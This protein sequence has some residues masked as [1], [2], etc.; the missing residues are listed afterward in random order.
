MGIYS[1]LGGKLERIAKLIS[2]KSPR[3]RYSGE[4]GDVVL[5]R[6]LEVGSKRWRV[7]CNAK[8]D[9]V[10]LLA[11]INLPGA[12]QRRKSH[13]DE[14]QMRSFYSEGE[15]LVAEVQTLYQDGAL[16]L[17]TRNNRYGK[18]GYGELIRVQAGLM[19]RSRSHFAKLNSNVEVILGM[20]GLV[21]VGPVRPEIPE[22]AITQPV[23]TEV[24]LEIR[25]EISTVRNTILE[26]DRKFMSIDEASL[27]EVLNRK[28]TV[29]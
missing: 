15:V 8:Q 25:K 27:M 20:N 23:Q 13:E 2:I 28:S 6:I 18:L 26:M 24:T 22:D 7:D 16:G 5:G 10:L 14:L 19:K 9:S 12:V 1:A 4:V 29:S 11:S 3:F 17:H 21:W